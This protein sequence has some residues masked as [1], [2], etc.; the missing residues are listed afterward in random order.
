MASVT[1]TNPFEISDGTTSIG[2][3]YDTFI[4]VSF[5]YDSHL[6]MGSSYILLRMGME[7]INFD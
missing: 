3:F 4:S 2:I 6:R 7:K 1:I 5:G